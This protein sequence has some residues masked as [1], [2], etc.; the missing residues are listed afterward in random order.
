MKDK[1][2]ITF[3]PS[4]FMGDVKVFEGRK[5][6]G[7]IYSSPEDMKKMIWNV[8]FY[9]VAKFQLSAAGDLFLYICVVIFCVM[10]GF[11]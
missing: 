5:S 1:A 3:F 2:K 10:P 9:T 6:P 11:S 4:V 7:H 8:T